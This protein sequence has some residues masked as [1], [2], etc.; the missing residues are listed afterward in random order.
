MVG[1]DRVIAARDRLVKDRVGQLQRH[2]HVLDRRLVVADEQTAVV[3]G[4]R[5]GFGSEPLENGFQIGYQHRGLTLGAARSAQLAVSPM[6][7][8]ALR[9][10]GRLPAT[11]SLRRRASPP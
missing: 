6:T 7:T 10:S 2:Q 1:Q 9:G 11:P 5:E 8:T 4:L 3:P